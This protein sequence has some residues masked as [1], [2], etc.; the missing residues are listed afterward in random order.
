MTM[1]QF[2]EAVLGGGLAYI[3]YNYFPNPLNLFFAVLM[4]LFTA[5]VVFLKINERPFSFYFLALIK[6]LVRPK[7]RIWQK[8]PGD[9]FEIEMYKP[10]KQDNQQVVRKNLDKKSIAE[11]AKNIDSQEIKNFKIGQK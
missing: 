11:I 10:V 8:D 6:F 9:G 5:C 3:C 1:I 2:V 4:G 7:Q